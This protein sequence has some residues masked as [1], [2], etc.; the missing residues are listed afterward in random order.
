M[1]HLLRGLGL[2]APLGIQGVPLGERREPIVAEVYPLPFMN[3]WHGTRQQG[4]WRSVHQDGFKYLWSS[5]D[6]H[7]LFD[8]RVDPGE[9]RNVLTESPRLAGRMD[10]ALTAYL[11]SLP[12]PGELGEVGT[13]SEET[14]ELLKGLGYIAEQ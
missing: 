11:E 3:E 6:N 8:L 9:T 2:E 1:P 12:P 4:D 13:V 14:L 10:A 5:R 7:Q